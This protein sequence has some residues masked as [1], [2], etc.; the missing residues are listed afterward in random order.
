MGE[1]P[2]LAALATSEKRDYLLAFAHQTYSTDPQ[3]ANLLPLLHTLEAVHPD[4][5]PTL[6]LISC[7]YYTRGELESSLYYNKRLLG[8]DPS[9]V[10]AMSNIGTTLRAMGKWMEAE[11]WWWKAIKLR[12]TCVLLSLSSS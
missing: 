6:L 1:M 11:A 3:S 8:F 5:L 4:H 2:D 10:E 7:V 12:P 9:Y